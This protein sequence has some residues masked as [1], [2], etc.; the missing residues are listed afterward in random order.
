M[1]PVSGEVTTEAP[2]SLVLLPSPAPPSF[3]LGFHDISGLGG[4]P[5]GLLAPSVSK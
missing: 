1:H 3:I 5:P 4:A 2:G